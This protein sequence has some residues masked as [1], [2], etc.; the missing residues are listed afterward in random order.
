MT[1]TPAEKTFVN[2]MIPH[3]LAG[4]S[5]EDAARAV[6]ADDERIWLASTAKDDMGEFIRRELAAQ[7]HCALR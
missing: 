5:F 4:K 1:M 7:I 2:R 6:L 3:V